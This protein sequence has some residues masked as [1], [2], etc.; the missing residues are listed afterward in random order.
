VRTLYNAKLD[1][2]LHIPL[3]KK[4]PALFEK[5]DKDEP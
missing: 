4:Y 2:E 5:P 1:E 3:K